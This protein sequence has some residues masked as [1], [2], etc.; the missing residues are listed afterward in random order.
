[1]FT[2]LM[3]RKCNSNII[4][5]IIWINLKTEGVDNSLT[6]LWGWS[7]G[8]GNDGKYLIWKCVI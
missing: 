7:L 1:M 3:H 8:G 5:I 6:D 2:Y 4:F